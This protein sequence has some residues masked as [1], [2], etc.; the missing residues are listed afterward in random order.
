LAVGF[1]VRPHNPDFANYCSHRAKKS[2]PPARTLR[3]VQILA[4]D[5]RFLHEARRFMPMPGYPKGQSMKA[6]GNFN[7]RSRQQSGV[8]ELLFLS[9]AP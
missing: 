4:N 3:P 5:G 2:K 9:L 1:V 6:L 7:D 8:T